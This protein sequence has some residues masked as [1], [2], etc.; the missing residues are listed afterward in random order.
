MESNNGAHDKALAG[1]CSSLLTGIG[2]SATLQ[3]SGQPFA[4]RH[5][6]TL[7][8]LA[9]STATHSYPNAINQNRP[10]GQ[11]KKD[12]PISESSPW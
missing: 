5:K 3:M 1:P 8:V 2:R 10:Q 6:A 12:I 9:R 11:R 4:I 7:A